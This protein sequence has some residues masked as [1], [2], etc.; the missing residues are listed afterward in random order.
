MGRPR[1]EI[2]TI[3]VRSRTISRQTV[4]V[5][6]ATADGETV[7]ILFLERTIRQSRFIK[8]SH[9]GRATQCWRSYAR[10]WW[11]TN[12]G[13]I[14]PGW[15]VYHLD[16]DYLNDDPANLAIGRQS[17]F[18]ILFSANPKLRKRQATNRAKAV[19]K[20]NA[21]RAAI[22]NA[23]TIQSR[24]WYVVGLSQGHVVMRPHNTKTEALS[25][26]KLWQAAKGAIWVACKG[27]D[28]LRATR[29]DMPLDG[30]RRIVP[31]L[32]MPD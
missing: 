15:S 11:L 24:K 26:A 6:V 14:P 23:S 18:E 10:Q 32:E 1:H 19:A 3:V 31:D 9:Y 16:G 27:S 25:F 12:R 20:S 17:H 28:I 2:G 5:H 29:P 22:R 21:E 4:P 7:T 30:F 8:V 13:P